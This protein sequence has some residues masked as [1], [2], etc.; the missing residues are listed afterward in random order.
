MSSILTPHVLLFLLHPKCK[1][2]QKSS[3]IDPS[4]SDKKSDLHRYPARLPASVP[5]VSAGDCRLW[6]AS[7]KGLQRSIQDDVMMI[8]F[9][10]WKYHLDV[11]SLNS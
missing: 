6:G 7:L 2:I 9:Y 5:A 11:D 4:Q 1:D 8:V 3:E 10:P